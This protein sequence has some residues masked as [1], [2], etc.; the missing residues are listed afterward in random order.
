DR[1][2][3]PPDQQDDSTDEP[4]DVGRAAHPAGSRQVLDDWSRPDDGLPRRR[5]RLVHRELRTH[6]ASA[7]RALSLPRMMDRPG[8][9][10]TRERDSM[11]GRGSN[12][13]DHVMHR[14]ESSLIVTP[15]VSRRSTM[16]VTNP[17][18]PRSW[19]REVVR[20]VSSGWWV[21]LLS[22][23]ISIVAGGIIL[24]V[25]WTV[26]DLAIFLGV[27]FVVPGV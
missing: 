24:L 3:V 2:R 18:G 27:G 20:S 4:D 25:D 12:T 15:T 9:P 13:R 16:L 26:H 1:G 6:D 22:G 8:T 19:S 14:A 7:S 17:L 11:P 21:L 23:I 10:I 5:G